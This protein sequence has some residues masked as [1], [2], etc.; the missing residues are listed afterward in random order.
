[1]QRKREMTWK[2]RKPEIDTQPI[3]DLKKGEQALSLNIEKDV[4]FRYRQTPIVNL[5]EP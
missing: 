1:M 2:R 3:R 5:I 4:P